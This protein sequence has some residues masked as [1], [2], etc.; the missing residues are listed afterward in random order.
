MNR[1]KKIM[2][3]DSLRRRVSE[4]VPQNKSGYIDSLAYL[5]KKSEKGR[6]VLRAI[7][8]IAASILIVTVV[9]VWALI[10]RGI[11]GTEP[12]LP[13]GTPEN[14]GGNYNVT[15]DKDG[16]ISDKKALQ[17]F[18][19]DYQSG[20]GASLSL[21]ISD[22]IKNTSGTRYTFL[23]SSNGMSTE[24]SGT[25]EDI[26]NYTFLVT[27][28]SKTW[29]IK[30]L[31]FI[32]LR[33][34][35]EYYIGSAKLDLSFIK[36][37]YENS[38][39]LY[40]SK[41]ALPVRIEN[42]KITQGEKE[43]SVFLNQYYTTHSAAI[44]ITGDNDMLLKKIGGSLCAVTENGV[45]ENLEIDFEYTENQA[46][47]LLSNKTEVTEL[48]SFDKQSIINSGILFN[49]QFIQISDY[50]SSY[51]YGYLS[52]SER[53]K[54]SDKLISL[55][56]DIKYTGKHEGIELEPHFELVFD[57]GVTLGL[58]APNGSVE[59][60]G[61][62]S[63]DGAFVTA[64]EFSD[65]L[66]KTLD[67]AL[68]PKPMT[69]E[70]KDLL[71]SVAKEHAFIALP[72][73]APDKSVDFYAARSYIYT[74]KGTDVAIR[75]DELNRLSL[76][77]FGVEFEEAKNGKILSSASNLERYLKEYSLVPSRCYF[78]G[79]TI[80]AVYDVTYNGN[81]PMATGQKVTVAYSSD[82]NGKSVDKILYANTLNVTKDN[83]DITNGKIEKYLDSTGEIEEYYIKEIKTYSD[84]DAF[85]I[86]L[87][88][89]KAD[90][91]AKEGFEE[92]WSGNTFTLSYLFH[93]GEIIG[94]ADARY[95]Y[96]NNMLKEAFTEHLYSIGGL[97]DAVIESVE[98]DKNGDDTRLIQNEFSSDE[99]GRLCAKVHYSVKPKK[100]GY[101]E[102]VAGNGTIDGD[103]IKDKTGFFYFTVDGETV[104]VDEIATGR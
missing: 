8:G 38:E 99:K 35:D 73:F 17:S 89:F 76:E 71:D 69:N 64:V 88:D 68:M 13:S 98:L 54:Y 97:K 4:N 7:S 45:T 51:V 90:I 32:F 21:F 78:E 70:Q 37:R 87:L 34:T 84:S 65:E 85:N 12:I 55:L 19:D 39:K 40:D 44:H 49:G 82:D 93:T 41:N 72:S 77:L 75:G 60:I 86:R 103:W 27:E 9:T 80:I 63:I 57:T 67:K 28:K 66:T 48:L 92:K 30:Y 3:P 56:R 5:G 33:D 20:K 16:N 81:E 83:T 2:P 74:L 101:D 29:N 53:L 24:T 94:D 10:G 6:A 26:G 14:F 52:D 59:N 42:G 47:I 104:T 31:P 23:V 102:W 46:R 100:A 11:R 36:N 22:G 58:S 25:G 50:D 61:L 18:F 62:I 43:F 15:I 95:E 1:F 96:I 91:K 79:T